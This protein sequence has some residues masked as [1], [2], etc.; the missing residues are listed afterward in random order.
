MFAAAINFDFAIDSAAF[1]I[2]AAGGA[3]KAPSGENQWHAPSPL[4]ISMK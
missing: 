1:A 4:I 2:D 3:T